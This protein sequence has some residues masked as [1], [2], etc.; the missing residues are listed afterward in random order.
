MNEKEEITN[1]NKS[2]LFIWKDIPGKDSGK[3]LK[4]L[5]DKLKISWTKTA[6][7]KKSDDGK[8]ISVIDKLNNKNLIEFK[9]NEKEGKVTLEILGSNHKYL[10]KEERGKT[11]VYKLR[12]DIK[13]YLD[14]LEKIIAGNNKSKKIKKADEAEEKKEGKYLFAWDD[15]P[16]KDNEQILK[17]LRN[18]LKIEWT[19]NAE[20]KKSNNKETITITNKNKNSESIVLKLNK[21]EKKI[22][23]EIT[24]GNRYE[25]ILKEEN[26]KLN[27]YEDKIQANI[28]EKI[29][30]INPEIFEKYATTAEI[31]IPKRTIDQVIGQDRAVEIIKNAAIQR[32]HIMLIGDP[33][34]GK[35]M[36][37][38]AMA[39]LLPVEELIDVLC[40]RNS[41]DEN[42]PKIKVVKTGEGKEIVK[43][44]SEDTQTPSSGESKTFLYIA[45]FFIIPLA[46]YFY[47]ITHYI[48]I[49]STIIFAPMIV[50]MF[51]I[52]FQ[53]INFRQMMGVPTR[54]NVPKI[55]VDNS[56]K[57]QVPFFDATGSHAGALLGDVKHDPLQSGGLGTPPHLRVMAG[58]MHKAHKGVLY[59]DEIS[60][61]G[62]S[63]MDLLT[64]MQEKQLSITGRSEMS[65][66]AMV[67]SDPV[68]CDFILVA[69][70]NL[71]DMEHMHPAL[72]SRIRGYGYEIYLDNTMPDTIENRRKLVR[73][74]TQEVI[75]D[76]KILHFTKEAVD[77]II[78]EAQRRSGMKGKLTLIFRE[79][80]GLI[81]AS[82]DLAIK[83]KHK[84]T[85]ADD[86]TDAKKIARTLEGQIGDIYLNKKKEY[87]VILTE[88]VSVGRVNGLA[89][90]GDV[91]TVLP[92]VA[93]VSPASNEKSGHIIATGKLGEIAKEAITNVSAIIKNFMGK[94]ISNYDIY[95]Q[96]LQTY[97]GVEGD[98]ASIAVAIAMISALE[99]VG[100]SQDVAITG[101][102]TVRGEVLPVGGVT[103]KIE[104]AIEAGLKK[105]IIPKS[106]E[107]DVLLEKRYEGKIEIIPVTTIVEAIKYAFKD[108]DKIMKKMNKTEN[109]AENKKALRAKLYFPDK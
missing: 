65:S 39:E 99:K 70:G 32:R 54:G 29:E 41:E 94:E 55:I 87:E 8:I 59:I 78:R 84:F 109:K 16:E 75:K 98:S 27:I 88:G 73:F 67:M 11:K 35:S 63:Q 53:G 43:K 81:R 83:R 38:K 46:I 80:G 77:V 96:F 7:I 10:L 33:G 26:G 45:V 61:I 56:N 97:E 2:Y 71:S 20:I 37:A 91:G 6:E 13:E 57:K 23:L 5:E 92:I 104:A 58:M 105:A 15:V 82:G 47:A 69:A 102:L 93:E 3:F 42:N 40:H 17:F 14:D 12:K 50:G 44:F 72:R 31:P 108:S 60:T 79:L 21:T 19:E 74:I 103:Q 85:E 106:N 22:S 107:K 95:V 66:G 30:D 64:A 76:G 24:G 101:S 49:D 100:I 36:L 86:V 28:V 51:L 62:K 18:D 9:F 34:T 89:V 4:F 25:Y 52:L 68:P 48:R 90:F 1:K